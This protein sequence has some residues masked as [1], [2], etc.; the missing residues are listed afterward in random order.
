MVATSASHISM[1]CCLYQQHK[2]H[3]NLQMTYISFIIYSILE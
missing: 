1:W 3:G 2:E